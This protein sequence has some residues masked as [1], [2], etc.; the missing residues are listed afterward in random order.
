MAKSAETILKPWNSSE[1]FAPPGMVEEEVGTEYLRELN[2][3]LYLRR[4]RILR[5]ISRE[6]VMRVTKVSPKYIEAME[7]NR[8]EDLPHKAFVVGFLRVF[9]SYAG[10]NADDIVNRYLTEVAQ[11]E[12]YEEKAAKK[13]PFWRRHL[14]KFVGLCGAIGLLA[15]MFAPLFHRS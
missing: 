3:G 4:E 7:S 12:A 2:F 10:L 9:S 11:Q 13:L 5:G 8:L 6:E 1:G 14:K 15:L